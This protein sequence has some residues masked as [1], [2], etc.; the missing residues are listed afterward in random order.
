MTCRTAVLSAAGRYLPL[1]LL[2]AAF[3]V[4]SVEGL[5]QTGAV[6]IDPPR[7]PQQHAESA[8]PLTG[9]Q[10]VEGVAPLEV[11]LYGG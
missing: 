9:E 1:S 11:A 10:V 6:L 5:A 8:R 4:T 7:S 3:A 2:A